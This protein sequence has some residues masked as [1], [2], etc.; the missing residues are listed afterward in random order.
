MQK[1]SSTIDLRDAI[2]VL[3]GKQALEE[4]RLR[5]QM[6]RTYESVQ[7]INIIKSTLKDALASR[8]L[9][10]D[11]F[12]VSVGLTAGYISK[13]LFES[14]THSPLRKLLGTTLMFGITN[15][16][17]KNPEAV[18][19]VWRSFFKLIRSKTADRRNITDNSYKEASL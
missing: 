4:K 5:D 15:V 19:A 7:P 3:E 11:F 17:A 2:I 8:E 9:K 6:H 12:N 10:D 13:V 14:V 18:K 1:I 16:V